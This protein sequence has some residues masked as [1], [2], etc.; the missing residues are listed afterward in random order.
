MPWATNSLQNM[1]ISSLKNTNEERVIH[2]FQGT[3]YTMEPIQEDNQQGEKIR[4]LSHI[5]KKRMSP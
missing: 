5:T 3:E 4:H 2:K 1:Y